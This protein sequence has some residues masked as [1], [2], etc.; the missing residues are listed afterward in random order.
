MPN[1]SRLALILSACVTLLCC[2]GLNGQSTGGSITGLVKD[3][4]G[5]VPQARVQVV[6]LLTGQIRFTS[7][8]DSGHYTISEVPSGQ[9]KVRVTASGYNPAEVG[10]APP[11]IPVH[12]SVAQVAQLEDI[13]LGPA[14]TPQTV[15]V[16]AA[17]LAMT[18]HSIPTLSTSFTTQQIEDLPVLSRD[19]N[20]LA[21]QAPGVFSV[22]TFSFAST[23]VPF[24]VNGSRGR[25]NNFIVD[26]VDNNEPLFG[27]AA[28]Q[29]TNND[30]F[31]E[32]RILTNQYQA[33]YGRNSGSVVNII[34]KQGGNQWHGS[35]FWF[36][37]NDR[38]D[39]M[40]S[41]EKRAALT[42]PA[43]YYE[44]QAGGTLG[45]PIKKD[46]SWVFLSYQWD[47]ARNDLS[48]VYPVVT[49]LPQ[50]LPPGLPGGPTLNLLASDPTVKTLPT[51]ASPCGNASS[52]LPV[53][54]PC[55]V[56]SVRWTDPNNSENTISIP[57]GTY[58]VPRGNIFDV[59]D[60]QLSGRWDQRL[61]ES[62]T[63]YARYLFDD[64]LTPRTA[65]GSPDQT[66]FAD[67]GL[68][69][70]WRNFFAQRT[71]NGGFFWTHAWASKLNELRLSY[72]RIS[73]LD[74]P[75]N[76]Q[77]NGFGK[78]A[79]TIFDRFALNPGNGGTTTATNNF[80][81][82]FPAAGSII[83][84]GS[85]SNATRFRSN[86]YQLQENFS[87]ALPKHTLKFG[88]DVVRTMSNLDQISSDLGHYFYNSF[89]DFL[90]NAPIFAFQRF[91]NPN[92]KGGEVLPIREWGQFYFFQDDIRVSQKFTLNLGVRYENYSPSYN[93]VVSQANNL[94]GLTKVS[95]V[96]TDFAPRLGFAW[97]LGSNTVLR[98]GY[99]IYYNPTFFNIALLTWQSG[100]ISPLVICPTSIHPSCSLSNSYP[101]APFTAGQ[102]TSA[103]I[104]QTTQNTVTSSLKNPYVHSWSLGLQR[105]LGKDFLFETSYV[106]S[107]GQRLFQR[108]DLNPKTGWQL[109][110]NP[111]VA[112]LNPRSDA[113]RGDITQV[114]NGAY[115][116]YHAL[117]L[118]ATK[119]LRRSG[120]WSGMAITGAYTWSHMTDNASEIFGPGLQDRS[121]GQLNPALV[122]VVTPLPQDSAHPGKEE[123]GNSSFDRRHR[124]AVSF[125]WALPSPSARFA[126]TLFGNWEWNGLF[127]LQSGQPFSPLNSFG[128]CT[129]SNGDGILTNDRPSIGNPKAPLNSVAL[130]ADPSCTSTAST[131][132]F[133]NGYMDPSGNPIDPATAHFVQNPLGVS[134]YKPFAVGSETFVAGN[135]G[136][137]TLVGPRLVN[138]DFSVVKNFHLSERSKLQF[139]AE[140][141]DI[142]NH[143]NPGYPFGNVFTANAQLSPA[144]AFGLGPLRT[145][146]SA[147]GATPEN[148]ID[149]KDFA[150]KSL[151]LSQQFLNTSSRRIQFA[152][153]LIF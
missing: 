69:P 105:Q 113:T 126:R 1:S 56:G 123:H 130:V 39:A 152:V 114:T 7:T 133:P 65:F 35:G 138:L 115:S 49:T 23:L 14:T 13:L 38:L 81:S 76:R 102:L 75:I 149:A 18:D 150:G 142:L 2:A 116:D 77:T 8:D 26:S 141:Y 54:N 147:T 139:R 25:D 41:V 93:N 98:G 135:A 120:I 140:F 86:I 153:K 78:P 63:V 125:L 79:V 27:G 42:S 148:S 143:A 87:I 58:L 66:A 36:G 83:T 118:S 5:P 71:Q 96:M 97:G 106:G 61:S 17:D 110:G 127:T 64:L 70:Q 31:S 50:S 144:A 88:A 132:N 73:S 85:D 122:E 146:A 37:Q 104:A 44:N 40:T 51:V 92:G 134:V 131:P 46:H 12:V 111:P 145:P 128:A 99:G 59:R 89:S 74:G 30:L 103:D 3:Q 94:A 22:R 11:S 55:T 62:D 136:R 129:D 124:V 100:P 90:N 60:H 72:S 112:V 121:L 43:P 108:L 34:T 9:Y 95:R 6:N 10:A 32:Y 53:Q 47:R 4:T 20:N 109:I 33:E 84:I 45:G 29:F 119:R 101:A 57:F 80:L 137:N 68:F 151:F 52:G 15:T 91:G 24:A 67:F 107:R 21:L 28:T 48:S 82:D 117:Q 16:V 19:T